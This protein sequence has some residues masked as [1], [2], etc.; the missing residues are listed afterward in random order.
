MGIGKNM[1]RVDAFD[2]VTGS[3]KYTADLE[4]QGLL[5]AKVIRSTIANGVVKSFD[6]EEALKVP[7]VVKIVTCF[8]VPDIQFPTPGHP[9]SVET[10][11][12]DI[13][14]RKL[15]NT[16]VRVYGDDIAAVIAENDIAAARAARLVKVEYEE[17]APLLTVE[18]A[19]A[20]DAP[21]LHDEKPGNVIAHS[22]FV[23]GEG[24]YGDAVK[25]EGLVEKKG[26]PDPERAALPYRDAHLLC[27]YGKGKNHRHY[28]HADPPYCAPRHQPGAGTAHG[29]YPRHQ[30]LHRRRFRQQAGC[31]L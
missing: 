10:A 18:D 14:D 24:T 29:P 8:D 13:A 27:L 5:A 23:V 19:M 22:S 21:R 30:A 17:Y 25:E 4:P 15:L 2:K 7:G 3:A 12:Q 16:R 11:H 9:W 31:A 1:T 6:L 20:E 26:L 28:I